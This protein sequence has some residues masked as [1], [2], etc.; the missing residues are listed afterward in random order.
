MLPPG[1]G[2]HLL[3]PHVFR[4]VHCCSEGLKL[5]VDI[6]VSALT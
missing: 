5:C 6:H 4:E 2:Q 1:D 3:K